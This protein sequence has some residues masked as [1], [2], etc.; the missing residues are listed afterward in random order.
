MDLER[1]ILYEE[2]EGLRLNTDGETGQGTSH[3][4]NVPAQQGQRYD[5]RKKLGGSIDI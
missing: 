3:P 5:V 1:H 2:G 4:S